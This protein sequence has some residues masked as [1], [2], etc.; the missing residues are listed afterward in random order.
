LGL[1][2]P[3]SRAAVEVA[4]R[5]ADGLATEEE[6]LSAY[7]EVK[8]F[9]VSV[10]PLTMLPFIAVRKEVM[11]GMDLLDSLKGSIPPII[12]ADLLRCLFGNPFRPTPT[13][14][15]AWMWANDRA[16]GLCAEG[17]YEERAWDALPILADA[18]EEAE[19][20]DAGL[21]AHLRSHGP[22]AR[23]CWVLDSLLGKE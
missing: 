4:E 5:Y 11:L 6:R 19:C 12:Q 3:R 22:H 17:I 13:I 7:V 15:P 8:L 16:A 20:D 10:K 23:G 21:L 9:A 2:D 18:L 1:T 14:D